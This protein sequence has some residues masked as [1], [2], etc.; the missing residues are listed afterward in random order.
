M[1]I[2]P[3][4]AEAISRGHQYMRIAGESKPAAPRSLSPCSFGT[5]LAETSRP[6]PQGATVMSRRTRLIAAGVLAL[7]S[8]A[9]TGALAAEAPAGHVSRAPHFRLAPTPF[10]PP[11]TPGLITPFI[12]LYALPHAPVKP[13]PER[14]M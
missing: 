8:A 12:K 3:V 6:M 14:A 10:Q 1:P 7:M 13:P 4:T 9:S 11:R 5:I 2:P